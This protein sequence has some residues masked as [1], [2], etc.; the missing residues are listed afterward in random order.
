[1]K[2]KTGSIIRQ[3]LRIIYALKKVGLDVQGY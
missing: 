2:K 3:V 1:M